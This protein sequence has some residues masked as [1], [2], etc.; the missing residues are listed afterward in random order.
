M[1]AVKGTLMANDNITIDN[2]PINNV[3][4]L[5]DRINKKQND[6]LAYQAKVLAMDNLELLMEL[7]NFSAL[8]LDLENA[9]Q[10]EVEKYSCVAQVASKKSLTPEMRKFAFL[11][12]GQLSEE[13]KRR[14]TG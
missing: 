11:L 2:S 8:R 4:Y 3:Y 13:L 14:K 12:W 10:F 5:K 9:I 6:L 1:I 7:T